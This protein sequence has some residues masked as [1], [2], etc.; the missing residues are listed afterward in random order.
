FAVLS[1]GDRPT[2]MWTSL[3]WLSTAARRISSSS[4]TASSVARAISTPASRGAAADRTS[5]RARYQWRTT[6][7]KLAEASKSLVGGAQPVVDPLEPRQARPAGRERFAAWLRSS[8][9]ARA[10]LES[11]LARRGDAER[12]VARPA[13]IAAEVLDDLLGEF[14]VLGARGVPQLL[15]LGLELLR[16]GLELAPPLPD[17][18]LGLRLL[19]QRSLR[20]HRRDVLSVDRE[21]LGA[22]R[23]GLDVARLGLRLDIRPRRAVELHETLAIGHDVPRAD[24][25]HR[26]RFRRRRLRLAHRRLRFAR[27]S[28]ADDGNQ[29]GGDAREHS[30][31]SHRLSFAGRAARAA[32]PGGRG[33]GGRAPLLFFI[34]VKG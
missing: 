11:G 25:G 22:H 23:D 33:G 19:G 12:R 28:G 9:A 4:P 18:G 26:S 14:R 16:V 31:T 2:W 32:P 8:H 27:A 30:R 13:R 24:L 21:R 10:G 15:G 34:A 29:C 20:E 6:G 7:G 3:A 1:I 17:L 5:L